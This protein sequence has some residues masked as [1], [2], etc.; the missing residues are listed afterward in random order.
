MSGVIAHRFSAAVST[1]PDVEVWFHFVALLL[2]F[3]VIALPS[4][5]QWGFLQIEVLRASWQ[6]ITG[7][8]TTS[9]VMPAVTEELFFLFWQHY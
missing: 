8:L 6:T 7:I 1:I 2:L 3:T 9:L 5:F 4:G